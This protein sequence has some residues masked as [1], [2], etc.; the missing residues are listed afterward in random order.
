MLYKQTVNAAAEAVSAPQPMITTTNAITTIKKC[1]SQ[2]CTSCCRTTQCNNQT[3]QR[4]RARAP[5]CS[6]AVNIC[7]ITYKQGAAEAG[8]IWYHTC[9]WHLYC[10]CGCT[11]DQNRVTITHTGARMHAHSGTHAPHTSGISCT[12]TADAT[13]TPLSASATASAPRHASDHEYSAPC[14]TFCCPPLRP[15]AAQPHMP[16]CHRPHQHQTQRCN[17]H[18]TCSR[19]AAV[20][21]TATQ[22][23]TR[24]SSTHRNRS[25]TH[26][27]CK[28]L[29]KGP[30][31]VTTITRGCRPHTRRALSAAHSLHP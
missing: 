19:H 12:P 30:A 16:Y 18:G 9:I 28:H 14:K 1:D 29:M 21:H 20:T 4:C 5:K 3:L 23:H 7:C 31:G 25:P 6:H 8:A 26:S 2:G 13:A 24:P 27:R 11:C 22:L 10:W 15:A 17:L